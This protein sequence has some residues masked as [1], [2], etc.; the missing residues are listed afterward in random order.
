MPESQERDNG[1]FVA[2]GQ[3][4]V[5]LEA[6][7]KAFDFVAVAVGFFVHR[8]LAGQGVRLMLGRLTRTKPNSNLTTALTLQYRPVNF[9]RAGHNHGRVVAGA[10]YGCRLGGEALAQGGVAQQA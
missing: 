6:A 1:F 4:P 7:K 5:L 2:R 9:Q 8:V 10:R 3:A